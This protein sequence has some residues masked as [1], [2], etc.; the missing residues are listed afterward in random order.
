[1]WYDG[2]YQ[3][4]ERLIKELPRYDPTSSEYT[5]ILARIAQID[6]I[7][8]NQEKRDRERN[9]DNI[10][11]DIQ[12]EQLKV[13]KAKVKADRFRTKV[14]LIGIG[15]Q[16]AAYFFGMTYSYKQEGEKYSLV[17]SKTCQNI[18]TGIMNRIRP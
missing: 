6:E 5:S 14:S 1:M 2:L 3:E 10:R 17:L 4:K 12:E 7:I 16:L 11:N 13:D 9:N 8:G 18:A 15:A